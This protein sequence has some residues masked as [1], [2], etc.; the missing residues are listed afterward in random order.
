MPFDGRSTLTD[1][2]DG[3]GLPSSGRGVRVVLSDF[4]FP[5]DPAALVRRLTRGADA[6]TLIQ[7]LS[8][9]EADP[10]AV[11]G[12]RLI[13]PEADES[14]EVTLDRA[15]VAAYRARLRALTDGLARAA[16]ACG[17][18]VRRRD[19]R[20]GRVGGG[21]PRR[22]RPRRGAGGAG[23]IA[24]ANPW[25]LLG[26]LAVPAVL[27]LHLYRVRFPPR[28]VGGLFLWDDSIRRPAGGRTR[29]RLRSTASLWLELLAAA[30]LALL[31]AGPRVSWE[32]EAPHLIAVVDGSASMTATRADGDPSTFRDAALAALAERAAAAGSDA[33]LT[34]IETGTRPRVIGGPRRP[35]R[36]AF[37]Q[38]ADRA[39]P[40]RPRHDF[41]PALDLAARLA[42]GW[43]AGRFCS[44]TGT[45]A[46]SIGRPPDIAAVSVGASPPQRVPARRGA[47]AWGKNGGENLFL[48]VRRFGGDG[49]VTIG[50]DWTPAEVTLGGGASSFLQAERRRVR[51]TPATRRGSLSR[52]GDRATES[53]RMTPS[54]PI[55]SAVLLPEPV[56]PVRVAVDLPRRSEPA[57]GGAGR[58]RT[59]RA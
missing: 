56:R 3:G 1:L 32:T 11:G 47:S 30:A 36:A 14:A 12:R 16:T 20:S 23:V 51:R 54:R 15:A 22:H 7:I 53:R 24:F 42:D 46:P 10:P 37:Q 9:F 31:L 34:L 59:F 38:Y 28:A 44:P 39:A 5:H 4:L 18:D 57:G 8:P 43:R 49:A 33:R 19:G 40:V 45:S 58:R 2:I 25:G 17:V 41:A 13:D 35:W 50:G 29:D 52:A 21:V 55:P 48:R 6:A 27:W 26:L